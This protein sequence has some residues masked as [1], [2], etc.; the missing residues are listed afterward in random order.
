MLGALA[1]ALADGAIAS[2]ITVDIDAIERARGAEYEADAGL[3]PKIGV[4]LGL[5]AIPPR[6]GDPNEKMLVVT[7]KGGPTPS[8]YEELS[9]LL[10]GAPLSEDDNPPIDEDLPAIRTKAQNMLP[11]LLARY[12]KMNHDEASLFVQIPFLNP[13]E[14]S[15][16]A[17]PMVEPEKFDFIWIDVTSWT[18]RP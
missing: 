6:E 1:Q 8:A 16:N 14:N 5:D 7:P 13:E 4:A 18:T 11:S 2:P 10:F 9:T 17:D 12:K 15:P 3:P